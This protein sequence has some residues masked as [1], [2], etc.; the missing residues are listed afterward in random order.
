MKPTVLPPKQEKKL[1]NFSKKVGRGINRFRMIEDGDSILL[2]ISGG[3]D[4]LCLSLALALRRFRVPISYSLQAAFIEW[5]EFSL[6][7]QQKEALQHFFAELEIPLKIVSAHMF[8]PSFKNKFNCYLCSRNKKRILFEEAKKLGISKIALGHHLDDFI[9]TT[10]MNMFFQGEFSTM[11]PVQSFFNGRIKLIRPLCEVT[12]KE[13]ERI[14]RICDLPLVSID[15]PNKETN[16]RTLMKDMI[17]RLSRVNKRVRE[18]I[19]NLPWRINE[20]YLPSG[21]NH[22]SK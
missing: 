12:E 20:K 22:D 9:E 13:I 6:E 18:N 15:C 8:P 4:S 10:M 2:G 3:K 19:Y 1:L 5:R 7:Q 11:M 21:L 17:K 16:L 14:V